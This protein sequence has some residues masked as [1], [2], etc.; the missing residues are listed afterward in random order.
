MTDK[1]SYALPDLF[2]YYDFTKQAS[3]KVS[4][5]FDLSATYDLGSGW[6]L[7]PHV[8]YQGVSKINDASYADYSLIA[9]KDLGSGLSVSGGIIGT[10][11][12][13]A[14][15]VPGASANSTS[16]LGKTAGLLSVKYTF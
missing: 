9:T 10:N 16:F 4:Y 3:S 14:F 7:T 2:G 12:S 5:Y 15:Y 13:K 6:T 8:G 11:A 1:L